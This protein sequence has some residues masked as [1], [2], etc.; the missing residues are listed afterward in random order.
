MMDENVIR[1]TSDN[2]CIV[3]KDSQW[4]DILNFLGATGAPLPDCISAS[5]M[6]ADP[7]QMDN[8]LAQ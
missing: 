3:L 6:H 5:P 7:R 4:N 8:D 2:V 1:D